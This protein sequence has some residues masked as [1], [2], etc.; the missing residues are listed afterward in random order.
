[1]IRIMKLVCAS[2][3]LCCGLFAAAVTMTGCS[4]S[5]STAEAPKV[6]GM[7]AGDYRDKMEL[8]AQKGSMKRARS[9]A[10][11]AR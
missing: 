10:K 3:V 6:D 9:S 7:S 2:G 1:M 11:K 5:A 4:G 8:E